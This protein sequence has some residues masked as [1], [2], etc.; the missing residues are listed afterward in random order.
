MPL[1]NAYTRAH[2]QRTH[3]GGPHP[4]PQDACPEQRINAALPHT[5]TCE[6]RT[7]RGASVGSQ[8]AGAVPASGD[9][10]LLGPRLSVSPAKGRAAGPAGPLSRLADSIAAAGFSMLIGGCY[11]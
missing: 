3:I 2:A 8:M 6:S 7:S 4:A 5:H 11:R 10:V 9:W 1:L